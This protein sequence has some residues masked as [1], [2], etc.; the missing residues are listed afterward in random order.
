MVV[1]EAVRHNRAESEPWHAGVHQRCYVGFT[2]SRH[3]LVR[4]DALQQLSD[5]GGLFAKLFRN[6]SRRRVPLRAWSA[7]SNSQIESDRFFRSAIHLDRGD[8]LTH[9]TAEPFAIREAA[10]AAVLL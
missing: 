2:S 5:R 1:I 9:L 3:H 7:R 10:V 4:F 8:M 6:R